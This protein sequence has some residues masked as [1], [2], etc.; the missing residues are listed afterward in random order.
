MPKLGLRQKLRSLDY[1]VPVTSVMIKQSR[2]VVGSVR[3]L[4]SKVPAPRSAPAGGAECHNMPSVWLRSS[5]QSPSGSWVL[6]SPPR[7]TPWSF[8][9]GGCKED[10]K[11][12][13]VAMSSTLGHPRTFPK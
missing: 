11:L 5:L 2:D 9:Q 12:L 4:P 1:C 3:E 7:Q 6:A 13:Y 8:V 10:T